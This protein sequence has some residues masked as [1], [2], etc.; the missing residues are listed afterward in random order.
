MSLLDNLEE[1]TK[2]YWEEA[3]DSITVLN[4]FFF[5][6]VWGGTSLSNC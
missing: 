5:L 3:T 2:G 4:L 1:V 6:F